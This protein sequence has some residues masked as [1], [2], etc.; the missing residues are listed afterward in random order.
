MAIPPA[1]SNELQAS[2]EGLS[3]PIDRGARF[4][5]EGVLAR[6]GMGV[7][8]RAVDV[9]LHRSLAVKE[10]SVPATASNAVAVSRFLEEARITAQLDHPGIVPV[11]EVG[12]SPEGH[13][14]FAMKLVAGR[15]LRAIFDC[16]REGRE[17][18]NQTRAVGVLLK[19]CEAMAY[20]HS[21][22]VIHRDL[23]PGNVMVGSYG[24]VYVMDWGLARAMGREEIHDLRLRLPEA[25][26]S[27]HTDRR[28]A[29]EDTP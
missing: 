1:D 2:L 20:A 18:W 27:L 9:E 24:E 3:R 29:R 6:G 25:T 14:Y 17:G 8:H 10:L 22:G 15:D 26:E 5:R 13:V 23:K 21:K 16:V 28:E 11:H 19:A 12:V 7:I 4:R